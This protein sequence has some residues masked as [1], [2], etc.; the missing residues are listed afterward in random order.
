MYAFAAEVV[1]YFHLAYVCVVV[2]GQLAILVGILRQWQWIR[3]AWF[4]WIHFLMVAIVTME[5]ILNI[6]CPL[7]TLE[8][9]LRSQAGQPDQEGAFLARWL[10]ALTLAMPD[11]A[12]TPMYLGVGLMVGATFVLAPPRRRKLTSLTIPRPAWDSSHP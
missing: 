9:H 2:F 10:D 6:N 7:L 8:D 12:Y 4:R 5:S 1:M 3:N 11:W